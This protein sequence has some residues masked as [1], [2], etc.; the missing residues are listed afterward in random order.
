MKWCAIISISMVKKIINYSLIIS[1]LFITSPLFSNAQTSSV[2]DMINISINPTNPEP[3]KQVSATLNSLSFNLD[4]TKITWSVNNVEKKTEIGLKN[5]Y[6]NSGDAGK[7]VTITAKITVSDGT[8]II[9]NYSFTPAGVDLIPEFLSYTPPFYKGKT[10]NP[11]QGAVLIVA[12]PEVFDRNG[13]KLATTELIFNW[14]KDGIVL[15]SASGLGKN[16]LTFTGSVPIRDSEI[17]VSVSSKDGS[18]NADKSIT[19]TNTSPKIVFYEN[20]PIYGIMMNKAIKNSVNMLIDEFSVLAV[21][22]FFSVG[23]ATTPDLKYD[24]TLNSNTVDNQDPKNS[25]TTRIEKAGS[26][27]AN[28]GLK[29]SNNIRIFQFV[30]NNYSINFSKE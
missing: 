3:N 20:N 30:D 8:V 29:I 25:F 22:Y 27:T 10:L 26:G 23:Y 5:F 1:F 14:E 11:N 24:W 9:K 12:F 17:S 4:S 6:F 21:P 15:Q 18:I 19:I 16:Y 28:I 7:T 13:R 2:G